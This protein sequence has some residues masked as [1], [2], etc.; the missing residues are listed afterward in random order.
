MAW[1]AD[2]LQVVVVV[3]AAISLWLDVVH[4]IERRDLASLDARLAQAHIP[5]DDNLA[6]ALPFSTISALLPRASVALPSA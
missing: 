3:C 4:L 1:T 2:A 5:C 6:Y